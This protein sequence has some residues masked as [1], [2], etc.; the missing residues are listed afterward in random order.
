MK[1]LKVL[2]S[3]ASIAGPA[4]AVWLDRY[5]ADVVVVEKAPRLREGGQLVDLRGISKEALQRMELDQQV[6]AVTEANYGLSFVDRR[7]RRRGELSV[8][9]FGADGPVAEIEILRGEL[10]Q[11]FYEASKGAVEY[12]FDDRIVEVRDGSD[13]VDVGF[14]SGSS[15]RFDLVVGADGVHS[16]LRDLVFG[17]QQKLVHLGTYLSFWTAENHM[18]LQDWSLAYSEPGRT[19]GMRSILGNDKVMAF[20]SFRGG[21]P[22]YDWRD[23]DAQ[24]RIVLARA[25]GMAWEA[26]QLLAQIETAPD[27]YFDTCTQVKLDRWSHGRVALVGDAAYCASPLSGHGATLATVGA[28]VLAGELARA[29]GNHEQAFAAYERKLRP[30]VELIH[31]SA[32][33]QG[34]IMTPET[35]FGIRLRNGLVRLA[36][37]LPGKQLL[38]RDQVRMSN[39]LELDEYAAPAAIA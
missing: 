16:E 10:S 5:G 26:A 32:P 15:E 28:Y 23:I 36:R 25:S 35:P 39:S 7:N 6:R 20:F 24:K 13:G 9:G 4:L 17:Q 27:F 31:R 38:I 21:P 18:D 12:R 1:G 33:D 30:W 29:D 14:E 2:I 19:I 3:G 34:K 22:A 37:Y 8:E 11:V